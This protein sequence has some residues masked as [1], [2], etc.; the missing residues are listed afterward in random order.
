MS[1]RQARC[2]QTQQLIGNTH[3]MCAVRVES[4]EILDMGRTM[5]WLLTR[6]ELSSASRFFRRCQWKVLAP[7]PRHGGA[8]GETVE[9]CRGGFDA[10]LQV[11]PALRDMLRAVTTIRHGPSQVRI[12][13]S[14]GARVQPR[15]DELSRIQPIG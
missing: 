8:I 12:L 15:L 10:Y 2:G 1:S 11:Y 7:C 13:F 5:D 3:S 4:C 14:P 9:S 6:G